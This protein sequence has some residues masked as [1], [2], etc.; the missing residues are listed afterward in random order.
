MFK[1]LSLPLRF[2]GL[3]DIKLRLQ[4]EITKRQRAEAAVR[5]SE[6]LNAAIL[7]SALD[8]IITIDAGGRIVE[9]NPAAEQ[10]FGYSRA[11]AI[12]KSMAELI[13]PAA[14]R[15][16]HARALASYLSTGK[17]RMLRKTL[18]LTAMRRDGSEFPCEL[19]VTQTSVANPPLFTGYLRDI[20]ERK[21][22]E[23]RFQL[24][25]ESAPNGFVMVDQAGRMVLVNSQT[26]KMFGYARDELLRQ[27]VEM[28]VPERFRKQHSQYRMGFF[29]DPKAR[30][31]GMGRDL[32]A[33]RKDGSEFPVEIGLNPIQTADGCLVLS[34][35]VDIT[36]RQQAEERFRRAVESATQG[37]VVIDQQGRALVVD[38]QGE[39]VVYSIGATRGQS[40]DLL[41]PDFRSLFE[42]A[43]GLF[44][45]LTPDLRIVAVSDLY[46]RATMT[47]RND[48]VGKKIFDVFP[49]NPDDPT[50]TGT[51]NLSDSLERV[52]R[53]RVADAMAVQKYDIRRPAAEGGAFAER[54][55]SPVNSPVFGEDGEVAFII[56]RVED[57]TE[58]VQLKQ[59]GEKQREA[60][61][62]LR[63]RAEHME[64]EIFL[65]AQELQNVNQRQRRANKALAAEIIERKRVEATLRASEERFRILIENVKDYA[66]FPLDWKGRVLSWNAG[67]EAINGYR[68]EEIVG[69]HFSRFYPQEAI[70]RGWPE[71]ELAN[72]AADGCFQ[73]AG[74]RVRKDGSR[75][76]AHVTITALRDASGK[77]IG[78]SKVSRDL[79]ERKHAEEKLA[80]YN[81]QLQRTNRELEA[82]NKEL[83]AF[84]YSVSHDLRT[85]L[86]SIDGFSQILLEEYSAALPSEAQEYLRD[87]RA[88][89]QQMGQLVDDLLALSRLSRQPLNT[90]RTEPAAIVHR[91]FDEL[92]KERAGRCVE[93][94]VGNLPVCPAD[95]ALLKQV[96]MNLLSNA[97]KYTSRRVA[98]RIEVGGKPEDST[99]D[100]LYFVKD[101]G[102][103]FDMRYAHK[104]F[105]VFQRL[106][107]AE[108]Y[109]GTGVGLA[110]VQRIIQRHGGR[111]WAEAQP[112]QGAT[113][114]F[115]LPNHGSQ[116]E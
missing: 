82:A 98:A 67:A 104:L 44:L 107:L 31:M 46:L 105:G 22:A 52:L 80:A 17:A 99:G 25:V 90:Q 91:C 78:F 65:R 66:I 45:V 24:V 64:G 89:T 86:R 79:T 9:F 42:S 76:W 110:I 59:C 92:Q 15:E 19:T 38:S 6:S 48:I 43:P 74:W 88:N 77:L 12:G 53:D 50:A 96:W 102:V 114:Y 2:P 4:E 35:I 41:A 47:K 21:R 101:N 85:P 115:T 28:L 5:I 30:A 26:E 23:Q 94:V 62:E 108:E 70:D 56:H 71:E 83:E 32:F 10:S 116:H 93:I 103:G 51:R 11:E 81:E 37:K 3:A 60:T 14:W 8:A 111:V 113:F 97:V 20:T 73:D 39:R 112:D 84:S 69:Q 36:Q 33:Q 29:A 58:F 106:H 63:R 18:E 100:F 54:Y 7:D 87:V 1:F 109:E 75:Y 13:I 61:E 49:D 16:A 55:W 57:V 68:A 27:P 40:A 95:P 34:T 72:A